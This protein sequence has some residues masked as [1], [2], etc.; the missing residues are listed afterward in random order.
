MKKY[1]I[2]VDGS[3]GTTGLEINERLTKRSDIEILQIDPENRKDIKTRKKYINSADIVFL[4]LPDFAA[5]ESVSLIENPNTRVIDA[6]TAHRTAEGW[7]YGI[8]ELS[9]NHRNNIKNAKRLANPGC[10]AT[11]FIMLTYPLVKEKIIPAD[12]P[13]A[14]HALTGYSGG[15]KKLI[16]IFQAD[17][18]K[19]KLNSPCFYSL[20]LNHKHLPEMQKQS[21]LK[22]PP[23]FTPIIANY[24]RGMA[25]AVPL[26]G[27]NIKAL[28]LNEFY[29]N[30]YSGQNFV[31]IP[32][33][34]IQEGFEWGYMNSESCNFTNNIEIL[35]FGNEEQVFACARFDNLGKGAS[36]AAVQ[37]MNIMLGFDETL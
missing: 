32:P 8:P 34:G 13:A 36:G 9:E 15:G 4:C 27:V 7:V 37:N 2:F 10:F 29:K 20:N 3:E 19:Q 22:K 18:N 24:Y 28:H 26:P 33:F 23:V 6:S 35:T 16:E 11:G 31:K 30:Y 17:E 12:Y 1:K 21:G 5:A 25:V 14:C